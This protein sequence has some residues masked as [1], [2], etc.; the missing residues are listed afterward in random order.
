MPTINSNK[1]LVSI[2]PGTARM[3]RIQARFFCSAGLYILVACLCSC[4]WI[5]GLD[6]KDLPPLDGGPDTGADGGDENGEAVNDGLEEPDGPDDA[7]V[8]DA[9]EEEVPTNCNF[10]QLSGGGHHTCALLDSGGIAC[11]GDNS[12]GQLG[13]GTTT[14]KMLHVDVHEL[15]SGASAVSSGSDHTCALLAD[16]AVKCWGSN[17]YGQLGNGNNVNQTTPFD[18]SG[19]TSGVGRISAGDFHT[20][21]LL[22]AGG[23]KCWGRNDEG[24]LGD[25]SDADQAAPVDV[26]GLTEGVAAISSGR[27]HTCALLSG[28]GAKCW[29]YNGYGQIGDNSSSGRNTPVDVH[30]LTSGVLEIEAGGYHTCARTGTE[31][32]M[33]WGL[34]AYG[35]I[36]DG[37]I[38]EENSRIA[39]V[40]VADLPQE[41]LGVSLGTYHTCVVLDSSGLKCWGDNFEGQLGDGTIIER[42][43]PVD[44]TGMSEGVVSISAGGFHTCAIMDSGQVRCWGSNISGCAGNGVR[45][46]R[47]IPADVPG[48][49]GTSILSTGNYHTCA[50]SETQ[51]TLCWG[52]N[53]YGQIG[54][55][56]L[57][58]KDTP[59]GVSELTS[60]LLAI[61]A[62]Q[63][64]TCALLAGGALRCWGRNE[65]GE[66]GDGTNIVAE[67][68][69]T[70]VILLGS[71]AVD[72]AAGDLHTCALLD[73]GGV[74]CWGD[75]ENGKLGIGTTGG[76]SNVPVNVSGLSSSVRAISA[77]RDYTCVLLDAGGVKCWGYNFFGMLGNGTFTDSSTPGNVLYGLPPEPLTGVAAVSAGGYHAC[78]LM[79]TGEVKCWGRNQNGQLGNGTETEGEP[80]PVDVTGLIAQ[81]S[82]IS[83]GTYHTCALLVTGD[84][85]CW[86]RNDNS[87]LGDGSMESRSNPVNVEGIGPGTGV[88]SIHAGSF[89]TCA[90][91]ES[92]SITCWGS[93]G[94]GQ[95]GDGGGTFLKTPV[96]VL[97]DE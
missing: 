1:C 15:S 72:V 61:S 96:N 43:R 66:L 80:L 70:S 92:G 38:G 21:A 33:C 78:A 36:G 44:V 42:T 51:G 86:G 20:C 13:D 53:D 55:G 7:Q 16:G 65:Y 67:T 11:W 94:Y 10:S 48:L 75:N 88:V 87:Q 45:A 28:G 6:R 54:D 8:D 76:S 39:P 12:Y 71:A 95:I 19:L 90:L 17:V 64:H 50:F 79:G 34:N 30:G 46:D 81:P 97:C 60:T 26:A 18:V 37:T 77:N 31:G 27:Y 25:G 49:A 84:V 89:H 63:H 85:V 59:V 29:G 91:L 83:A 69:P 3:G 35:Q 5:A 24:Q 74:Q 4:Q 52:R 56:T 14:D 73:S 68:E 47:P 32:V 9:G 41:V 22:A 2:S 93:N 23:V 40:G 57:E 62:G 58:E 82:M